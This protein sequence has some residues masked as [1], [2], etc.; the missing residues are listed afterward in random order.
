V[1]FTLAKLV[2]NS[3]FLIAESIVKE[4]KSADYDEVKS[5]KGFI[6]FYLS[7][8]LIK[9]Q[10]LIL[11]SPNLISKVEKAKSINIE[12]LSA[13]PT[14]SLHIG[15]GRQAAIGD[16]IARLLKEIGH[17]VT[18]EYY[19]NDAGVQIDNLAK[20]IDIR[21]RQ[22]LGEKIEM[23]EDG[24]HGQDATNL[25]YQ[26][27]ESLST[28]YPT[29]TGEKRFNKIKQLA[30]KYEMAQIRKILRQYRVKFDVFSS[31]KKIRASGKIQKILEVLNDKQLLKKEDGAT[32]FLSTK[33]DDDKDRVLIKSDGTYT[34][35]TPDIAYH[36]DKIERKYDQLIDIFGADHY[37]YLPRMK[38]A[39]AALGFDI[40][41]LDFIIVQMVR[42]YK[43]GQEYK[44]SKRSG[45]SVTIQDMIEEIGVDALRYVFVSRSAD[46]HYDIE[47]E[48]LKKHNDENPVYYIQY[49]YARIN[50]IIKLA[51]KFN[52]N[53]Q[54]DTFDNHPKTR[55]LIRL[56]LSYDKIVHDAAQ[57]LAPFKLTNY[58]SKLAEVFH[59]FY[60]NCRIINEQERNIAQFR[61]YLITITAK[62]IKK[63]L[64]LI[65]VG[66]PTTM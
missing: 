31:E 37:G 7:P 40:N 58:L 25:A 1:A 61:L 50:S 30:L 2:H 33:Y 39:I 43:D 57:S 28:K 27:E 8:E 60:T 56:L 46:N 14:G 10:L 6:N 54:I 16:S 13:N 26:V 20:T 11:N 38:A 24:Y 22:R 65:G 51:G 48:Q 53:P 62:I 64:Q 45:N 9:R 47:I 17:Q 59:G 55:E 3:P 49:A 42:L 15:H 19:I 63:S 5:E 41:C 36:Q 52:L 29:L 18:C 12:F 32:F 35:L 4:L 23:I 44:L 66:A 34:Y 21:I